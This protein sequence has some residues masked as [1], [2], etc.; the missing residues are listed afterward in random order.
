MNAND[1]I[2]AEE[3]KLVARFH[4]DRPAEPGCP[5]LTDLAAYMDG[6]TDEAETERIEAHLAD[7]PECRKVV[8]EIRDLLAAPAMVAPKA[9]LDRAKALAPL[10]ERRWLAVA[11]W[12]A[13]VAASILIGLAGLLAGSSVYQNRRQAEERLTSAI[14]FDLVALDAGQDVTG[15]N[16]FEILA[17]QDEEVQ[18]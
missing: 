9:V 15:D 1:S 3:R 12:T 18:R 17:A 13:A 16:V 7:C 14:T 4:R 8:I 5:T 6:H 10:R 11:R 2:S